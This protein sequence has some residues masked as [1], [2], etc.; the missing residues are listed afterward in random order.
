MK[1]LFITV[2]CICLGCVMLGCSE[3]N[4]VNQ[5]EQNQQMY[6]KAKEQYNAQEYQGAYDMF[7][8]LGDY[9]DSEELANQCYYFLAN[10]MMENGDYDGAIAAFEVL[11]D[12]K[13]TKQIILQCKYFIV[14]GLINN[15][16]Y[17]KAYAEAEKLRGEIDVSELLQQIYYVQ[18]RELFRQGK[19]DAAITKLKEAVNYQDTNSY[20]YKIGKKYNRT[21]RYKK[22]ANAFGLIP[23]YKNS[24]KMWKQSKLNFK[25]E[26]YVKDGLKLDWYETAYDGSVKKLERVAS[27]L[28]GTWYNTETNKKL[29]ITADKINGKIYQVYS[30][31][32]VS[33][34]QELLMVYFYP[35]KPK[36]LYSY[37]L[38]FK[39][40]ANDAAYFVFG[41]FEH[42]MLTSKKGYFCMKKKADYDAMM[43]KQEAIWERQRREMEEE[44]KKKRKKAETES[45]NSSG[46]SNSLSSE[47]IFNIGASFLGEA[48]AKIGKQCQ[49]VENYRASRTIG[50]DA[51]FKVYIP[52]ENAYRYLHILF[53]EDYFGNYVFSQAQLN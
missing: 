43:E 25:Y 41:Y 20:I 27:D 26:R 28:Y 13:D 3:S 23:D 42:D 9:E 36:T 6:Q 29:K 5:V 15:G 19:L 53:T 11:G 31:Y 7:V 48:C 37:C 1:K 30:M 14:V 18:G 44:D 32:Y 52:A 35:D 40:F 24:K 46:Q 16:E 2:L 34:S 38:H 50:Y 17:D 33:D 47:D 22:A 8:K 12:Y 45:N 51:T 21:K 39:A 49:I 4:N 10:E